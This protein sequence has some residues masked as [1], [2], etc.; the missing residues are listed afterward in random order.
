MIIKHIPDWLS[1]DAMINRLMPLC[2]K[3]VELLALS[4]HCV[5]NY[6]LRVLFWQLW[7]SFCPY[8]N[9]CDKHHY[10]KFIGCFGQLGESLNFFPKQNR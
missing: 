5:E 3:F 6:S 1:G 7:V 2:V 8:A 9:F 4:V 10:L